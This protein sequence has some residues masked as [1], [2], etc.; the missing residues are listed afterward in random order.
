MDFLR[1]EGRNFGMRVNLALGFSFAVYFRDIE[2]RLL[3]NIL[4]ENCR[5]RNPRNPKQRLQQ[6][7]NSESDN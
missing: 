6:Q 4:E 5:L 7:S 3:V 2:N 1:R